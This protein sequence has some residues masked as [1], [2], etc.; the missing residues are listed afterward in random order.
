MSDEVNNKLKDFPDFA[1]P[2]GP[3]TRL[4]EP[5]GRPALFQS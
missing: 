5:D 4:P 1:P 3:S 2:P